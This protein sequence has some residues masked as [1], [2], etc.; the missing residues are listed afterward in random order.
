MR[1]CIFFV[2]IHVPFRAYLGRIGENKLVLRM[3][4]NLSH[5]FFRSKCD[6]VTDRFSEPKYKDDAY[7]HES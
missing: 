3:G 6:A 4:A 1:A 5:F 2:R 7:G